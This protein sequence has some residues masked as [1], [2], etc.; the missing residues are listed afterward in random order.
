[1][2]AQTVRVEE[3]LGLVR[4]VVGRFRSNINA[5]DVEDAIQEGCIGLATALSR[6]DGRCKVSTYAY[7]WIKKFVR[8]FVHARGTVHGTPYGRRA[9]PEIAWPTRVSLDSKDQRG[10]GHPELPV[11]DRVAAG[12][13]ALDVSR[14][15][16]M[17]GEYDANLLRRRWG[18]GCD[19]ETLDEIGKSLGRTREAIRRRELRA[20]WRLQRAAGVVRG[21]EPRLTS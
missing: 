13:A 7:P 19:P 3:H 21:P 17:L 1:M 10:N 12:N 4:S 15:L 8:E 9:H 11:A 6:Y 5:D 2:S 16:G 18:I 14:L 20:F